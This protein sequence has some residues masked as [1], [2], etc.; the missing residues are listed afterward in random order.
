MKRTYG[1]KQMAI[2]LLLMVFLLSYLVAF[3]DGILPSLSE[4]VGVAMPSL[5]E[6]LQ[7]YPD[8]E[9]KN[10]DG[11]NTEFYANISETDFNVFSVYL[12]AQGAAL[13][14]YHVEGD[15][16]IAEIRANGSSFALSFDSKTGDAK[17]TYPAG[18]YDERVRNASTHFATVEELLNEG[19]KD[20]AIAELLTIPQYAEFAPVKDLF[21]KDEMLAKSASY[22]T[23]IA[24]FKVVDNVVTF[25]RFEQDNDTA[26]GPEDIEWIVLDY[27]QNEHK[28]LLLSLYGLNVEETHVDSGEYTWEKSKVR[29]WLNNEF[30]KSAFSKEETAAI[31]TT[32]VDN[33]ISQC[34]TKSE[35]GGNNTK[36]RIFV[37]SYAEGHNYLG[38]EYDKHNDKAKCIPTEYANAQNLQRRNK[39]FK[40]SSDIETDWW[41][42]L[43]GNRRNS[44]SYVY[45]G[46]YQNSTHY[47]M[48]LIRPVMWIDLSSNFFSE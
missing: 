8:S 42:R 7:R 40:Y 31:L 34:Y 20:D 10:E 44:A 38:L 21:E 26:N 46:G 28:T 11:S 16:L 43:S 22:E 13:A 41:L 17:V 18:S 3:A 23:K 36:D 37:L 29:K 35:Y 25:G 14:D 45:Y 47:G 24:P 6:A 27:N 2:I 30:L 9:T 12:E 39:K 32:M 5:G 1:I 15:E 19:K 4:A 33:G 48:A